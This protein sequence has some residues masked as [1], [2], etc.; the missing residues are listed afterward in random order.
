MQLDPETIRKLAKLTL[1]TKPKE[2]SCDDWIH[3]VGEFVEA[4]GRPD[5]D[6]RLRVVDRHAADCPSCAE[7]LEALRGLLGGDGD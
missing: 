7:E 2:I 1:E 4:E 6:E 5:L 3:R